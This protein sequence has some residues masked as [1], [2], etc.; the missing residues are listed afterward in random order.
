MPPIRAPPMRYPLTHP[1]EA[2]V[3]ARSPGGW[4]QSH[5]RRRPRRS[6]ARGHHRR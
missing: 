5:R 4:S 2:W 3:W 6:R 1:P